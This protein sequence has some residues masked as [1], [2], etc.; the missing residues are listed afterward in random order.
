MN[1]EHTRSYGV[2]TQLLHWFIGALI[3]AEIVMALIAEDM[4]AGAELE[5]MV[6]L[7]KSLG[8]TLLI[9]IAIRVGW[10]YLEGSAPPYT[11]ISK[12]S[13]KLARYGHRA[14]YFLMVFMPL[15][16]WLMSST[17]GHQVIPFG[18]FEF[19][20]LLSPNDLLHDVLET[21][22]AVASKLMILLIIIHVIAS[23]RHQFV[24]R[25]DVFSRVLPFAGRNPNE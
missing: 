7:H 17:G 6:D 2:V 20:A 23:L 21:S 19:P 4:P 24:E 11:G 16:G 5:Q 14:L 13:E 15:S 10:R 3:I 1:K 18:L 9:L 12:R 25:V 8:I 22:H